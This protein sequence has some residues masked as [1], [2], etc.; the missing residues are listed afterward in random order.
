MHSWMTFFKPMKLYT[1]L[2]VLCLWLIQHE[3]FFLAITCVFREGPLCAS[4]LLS[5]LHKLLHLIYLEILEI[6]FEKDWCMHSKTYVI[7]SY[8]VVHTY[9]HLMD[10]WIKCWKITTFQSLNFDSIYLHI[11]RL[12]CQVKIGLNFVTI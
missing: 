9:I 5:S 3:V 6:F 8:I 2:L 1:A 11:F 4:I 12:K 7:F 10:Y